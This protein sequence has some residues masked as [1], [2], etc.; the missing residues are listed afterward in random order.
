MSASAPSLHK[1]MDNKCPLNNKDYDRSPQIKPD[2]CLRQL[3]LSVIPQHHNETSSGTP[4]QFQIKYHKASELPHFFVPLTPAALAGYD[5]ALVQAVRRQ[6]VEQLR[7]WHHQGRCLHAGNPY[8]ETILHAAAR[9]GATAVVKLLL[10]ECRD[11]P[12]QVCCDYQRTVLHDAC[13]TVTPHWDCIELILD[14]CPDLLFVQ[15]C[16]GNTPLQYVP[17]EHWGDW[18]RFL[19][20]R[21]EQP[22]QDRNNKSKLEPRELQVIVPVQ[23][24]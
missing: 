16:R 19:K 3:L 15:D 7:A 1:T 8:G 24:E 5:M 11:V 12:V 10:Y 23:D 13:W 2:D 4:P 9:R 18:C 17:K 14:A 20:L 6:D 21:H 22:C